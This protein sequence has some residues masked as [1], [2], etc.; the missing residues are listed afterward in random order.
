M[1]QLRR[2]QLDE[3]LTYGA[4]ALDLTPT[5]YQDAIQKYQ[6]VG[7][8]LNKPNS[9]LANANPL[10]Y[11][12]GSIA[13]GTATKPVGHD[14]FD[15]DL[16]CQLQINDYIS[17]EQLKRAIGNRLKEN[18]IYQERLEE[19]NRCW[20]IIYSGEFHMDILPARPD[21]NF[22]EQTALLVPDKELRA[23]KESNPKGFAAWFLERSKLSP[24]TNANVR[25][26]VEPPPPPATATTKTP[27]QLAVQI[28]K[29]HRDIYFGRDEDAPISIII[30]TLAAKAYVGQNSIYDTLQHLL[31][32]M[33]TFIETDAAGSPFIGNPVNLKENFADK[34]KDNLRKQSC[35]YDWIQAASNELHRISNTLLTQSVEA[36]TPLIGERPATEAVRQYAT[37][38]QNLRTRG[39]RVAA[40]TG[41]LAATA[42]NARPVPNNTF[43]GGA[44]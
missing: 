13:I 37:A 19:K 24:L 26:D 11:P 9:I 17:P 23:W 3:L 43:F 29:R 30:T 12:Q 27:L 38:M 42:A 31:V 33:P 8:W 2:S 44:L 22:P 34:W 41:V 7:A 14:E 10:I 39:L 32:R 6:A 36:L 21:A 15:L 28:L 5:Q 4:D 20:R 1:D 35:F 16:V 18:A 40:S 25:A